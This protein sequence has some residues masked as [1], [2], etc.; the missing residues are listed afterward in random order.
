MFELNFTEEQKMLREMVRDFADNELKPIASQIDENEAI[1]MEIIQKIGELG[2]LGAAFPIEYGGSGFGEVGYCIIQ[3]EIG[4]ACLSTATFIG[5]H[6]SIGT[7]A[8]YLGGSEE[9]RKKYVVPLASGEKVAAFALTEERA[10]SDAFDLRTKAVPDGDDWVI[11]GEKQWITNG[12]FADTFSVFART[13]RGITA[14]VVEKEAPGFSSGAPEKKMGIRGSK[15]SSLTFDNVRV[16]K[17][18]MLGGEGRGFLLAMKTLDAGRLG[19]GAACLGACKELLE[20]STK[21][22]KERKQF[23]EPIANFQAIQFMLAEMATLIYTSES[24]VYRTA[25]LYDKHEM[26]S[27]QS[28]MVKLFVSE[29]LDKC[30][31]YAMQIH[32]GMGFSREMPIERFYR[33]SRINRIFEGTSEIQKLVIARD[34]IKRNGIV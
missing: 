21:Y 30:V 26:L 14:F 19:L 27:R 17:E 13:P 6:V 12:P 5:A 33:D 29:A 31:D 18:N 20:L 28:A 3:E 2:I 1:P 9:I 24:L 4:R 16:P 7:N 15:T 25:V 11:N 34:I 32:G 22:A 8:I 23:G 10:G